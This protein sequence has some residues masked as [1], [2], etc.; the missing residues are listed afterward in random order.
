MRMRFLA[1]MILTSCAPSLTQVAPGLEFELAPGH[2]VQLAETGV[3]LSMVDVANDSRCPVDVVC[4]TAGNAEVRFRVRGEGD[5]RV[6][7]L[8]TMQEPK[9]V[10]V[11]AVRL[12]LV[13]LAPPRRAG[14]PPVPAEYRAR[15]RWS[16]P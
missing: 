9:A 16:T 1:A 7:S 11:G 2:T 12:E 10:T 8:H 5:E 14:V 4:V 15:I 3:I 6:V 13:S